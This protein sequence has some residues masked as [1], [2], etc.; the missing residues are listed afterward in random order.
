VRGSVDIHH[1][2]HLSNDFSAS[3]VIELVDDLLLSAALM[4]YLIRGDCSSCNLK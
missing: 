1:L 4:G 2:Q 3:S